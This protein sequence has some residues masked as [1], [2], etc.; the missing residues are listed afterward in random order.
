MLGLQS[1]PQP[2]CSIDRLQQAA[3]KISVRK[4]DKVTYSVS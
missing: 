1:P 3:C 4:T 2:T